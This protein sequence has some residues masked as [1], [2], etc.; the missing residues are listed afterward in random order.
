MTKGE[1]EN[2]K[3]KER[4]TFPGNCQHKSKETKREEKE[5]MLEY[6]KWGC[7]H[8]EGKRGGYGKT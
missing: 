7:N 2:G 8:N 5:E 4:K 1:K 3:K 6:E